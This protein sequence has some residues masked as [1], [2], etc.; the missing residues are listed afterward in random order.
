MQGMRHGLPGARLVL[1]GVLLAGLAVPAAARDAGQRAREAFEGVFGGGPRES[2]ASARPDEDALSAI[3]ASQLWDAFLTR[4]V[5]RSAGESGDLALR[6]E[7]LGALLSGRHD[8]LSL[9]AGAAPVSDPLGQLFRQSWERLSPLLERLTGELEERAA[10]PFR[11]L[12]EGGEALKAA[13]ALGRAVGAEVSPDSLRQLARLVLPAEAGDPLAW[14]LDL[15]PELRSLFG[16]GPPLPPPEPSP[17]LTAA[18]VR[19]FDPLGWLVAPAFAAPVP[20]PAPLD[21]ETA[22]L[23]TRLNAWLPAR[24]DLTA[25]LIEM[26]TLLQRTAET[27]LRDREGAGRTLEP[28]FHELYRDLVLATAWKESCWRQFVRKKGKVQ[29]IQSGVG[30]VGLMQVYP[31]VWRG[32]YDV[33]GLQQDV[34]YNGRA[35]TEILYHYLRDYAIRKG[36]HTVTG[37]PDNLA[38]ATYAVYNGGPGHLRRYRNPKERADL[39]AIDLSFFEKYLAVKAGGELEVA[40]CFN[41]A[42]SAR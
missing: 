22:A 21:P 5:K 2:P 14:D 11:A 1:L 17:L 39:K 8:G 35:G 12:V 19:R 36:E 16:F 15:D 42:E 26:R 27:T 24:A 3:E 29:P 40:S 41:G 23:A 32:F 38:R 18:A 37:D 4:V 30:A 20:P 6:G 33:S 13:Q 34:A 7:F 9:I 31:R 28:R 10:Q 25:Y